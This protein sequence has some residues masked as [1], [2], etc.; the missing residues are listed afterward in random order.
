M[1]SSA[2]LMLTITW[3]VI[4]YFTARFFLKVLTTPQRSHDD[5]E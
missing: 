1:T 2:W 4:V 5:E 3:G